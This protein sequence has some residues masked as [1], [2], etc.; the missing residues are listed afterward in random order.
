MIS[1][2]KLLRPATSIAIQ[3]HFPPS[4]EENSVAHNTENMRNIQD[5][6]LMRPIKSPI[7]LI[8]HRI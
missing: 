3:L 2:P 1:G 8:H 7:K 6:T 5:Q 4:G